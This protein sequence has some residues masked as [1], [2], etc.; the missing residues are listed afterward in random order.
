MT[1]KMIAYTLGLL[2][3]VASA[4][5]A[6]AATVVQ[7]YNFQAKLN[8]NSK[9][10]T[11]GFTLVQDDVAKT[12]TLQSINFTIG[13]T[14]Y[15]TTTALLTRLS[16]VPATSPQAFRLWGNVNNPFGQ[17]V[18]G[19]TEDFSFD[20]NPFTLATWNFLYSEA[21]PTYAVKSSTGSNLTI[22]VAS[23][24][25][26]AAWAMMIGGFAL[27]GMALRRRK[28]DVRFA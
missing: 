1:M 5:A 28:L 14:V 2:A 3:I 21:N 12:A 8:D 22:A 25:E 4:N 26:S 23:V 11:G 6:Q 24:P 7:S 16:E 19:T 9:I 10:V 15:N 17:G 18:Q 27:A 13:S 20:F